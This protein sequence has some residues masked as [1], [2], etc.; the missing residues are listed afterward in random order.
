MET[1]LSVNN[2]VKETQLWRNLSQRPKS[3]REIIQAMTRSG[4]AIWR[5]LQCKDYV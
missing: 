4:R 2:T 3:K 5:P 1:H